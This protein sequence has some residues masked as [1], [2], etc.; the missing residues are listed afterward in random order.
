M[1]NHDGNK[2]IHEKIEDRTYGVESNI[3]YQFLENNW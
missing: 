1:I 2:H 3:R